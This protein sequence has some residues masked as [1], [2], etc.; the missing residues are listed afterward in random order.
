MV[1]V[2][3]WLQYVGYNR[4]LQYSTVRYSSQMGLDGSCHLN[5]RC[6]SDQVLI[7]ALTV[8][9]YLVVA[10]WLRTQSPV[11]LGIHAQRGMQMSHTCA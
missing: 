8:Q 6:Q 10:S 7:Y 2:A 4:S 9:V 5:L 11:P 1:T 3:G